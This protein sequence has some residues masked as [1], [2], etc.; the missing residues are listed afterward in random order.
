MTAAYAVVLDTCV[1]FGAHRRDTLLRMAEAR[2]FRPL[3]TAD[4][5]SELEHALVERGV[6]PARAARVVALMREH[7]ED[8]LVDGYQ[9][10]VDSMRNDPKDRHVLAAAVR[11]NAAAI[12][13]DNVRDFPESATKPYG[14][15]VVTVDEFML[16][17]LDLAPGVVMRVLHDQAAAHRR[18]PYT[19]EGLL[20]SLEKAG[21]AGFAAEARR[22]LPPLDL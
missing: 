21:L 20:T 5:L 13:T 12:V 8:A 18:A 2:L 16:N 7:F 10:L 14:V 4:I 11:A 15:E 19:V 9:P 6:D 3:W 17:Q 22:H 1:L